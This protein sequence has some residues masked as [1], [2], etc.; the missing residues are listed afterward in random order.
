MIDFTNLLIIVT[1]KTYI[2]A[3]VFIVFILKKDRIKINSTYKI[4]D[5]LY[6][7]FIYTFYIFLNN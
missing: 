3:L 2:G 1:V 7:L 6:L 5:E 4:Y